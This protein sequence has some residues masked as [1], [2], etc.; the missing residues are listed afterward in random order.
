MTEACWKWDILLRAAAPSVISPLFSTNCDHYSAETASDSIIAVAP[1]ATPPFQ[2]ILPESFPGC[3]LRSP[4]IYKH[5]EHQRQ[6]S[7]QPRSKKHWSTIFSGAGI[8]WDRRSEVA[9][10]HVPPG[11]CSHLAH[12]FWSDFV[13]FCSIHLYKV[14]TGVREASSWLKVSPFES[15]SSF[16]ECGLL[17]IKSCCSPTEQRNEPGLFT[18]R[19]WFTLS[20]SRVLTSPAKCIWFKINFSVNLSNFVV[21]WRDPYN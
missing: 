12:C 21:L 14:V 8:K 3:P 5:P 7:R 4:Q 20:S 16:C 19:L 11:K 9:E 2:S 6:G 10:T 1:V 15:Q 18:S 13:L 17:T